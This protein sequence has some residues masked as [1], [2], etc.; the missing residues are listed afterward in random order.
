MLPCRSGRSRFLGASS[1]LFIVLGSLNLAG[2]STPEPGPSTGG[3]PRARPGEEGLT[4]IPIAKGYDA[5]GLVLPEFDR[6]GRLR[7]KLE[8]GVTR[9]LDD[10]RVEFNAVKY[11]T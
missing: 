8:A 2:E 4:N 6:K 10:D 1:A 3:A 11:T 7:G 5:K 9:R